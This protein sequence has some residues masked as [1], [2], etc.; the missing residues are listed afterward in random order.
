M[1]DR[2][3]TT[4]PSWLEAIGG[5]STIVLDP[6][7]TPRSFPWV[8]GARFIWLPRLGW[9]RRP[10]NGSNDRASPQRASDHVSLRR[11]G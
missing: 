5:D 4:A 9:F 3:R 6:V 11:I 7:S 10:S 1:P 8:V 2:T